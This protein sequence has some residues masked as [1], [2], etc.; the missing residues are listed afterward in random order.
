MIR[1]LALNE[2]VVQINTVFDRPDP[3]IMAG[4]IH[5]IKQ[6]LMI[7]GAEAEQALFFLAAVF[8]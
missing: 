3:A 6:I 7:D 2:R 1:S 8:I 5:I 4:S